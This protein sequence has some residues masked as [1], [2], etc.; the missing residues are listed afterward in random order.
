M[1][2]PVLLGKRQFSF[3]YGLTFQTEYERWSFPRSILKY[4]IF[5]MIGKDDIY[6]SGKYDLTV[7]QKTQRLYDIFLEKYTVKDDRSGIIA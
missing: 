2:C 5:F 4:D 7:C 6:F 3:L 1:I